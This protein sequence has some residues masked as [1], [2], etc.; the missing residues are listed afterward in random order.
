[1][2]HMKISTVM[3][4]KRFTY[5]IHLEVHVHAAAPSTLKWLC[6][7]VPNITLHENSLAK[8]GGAEIFESLRKLT[9]L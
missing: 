7:P 3:S 6:E 5:R 8:V 4:Q 9:T 1:M 2:K